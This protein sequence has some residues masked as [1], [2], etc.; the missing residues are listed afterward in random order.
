M[1]VSLWRSAMTS[2]LNALLVESYI[3]WYFESIR[4]LKSKAKMKFIEE[5]NTKK[6]QPNNIKGITKQGTAI[7][8][9]FVAF[10]LLLLTVMVCLVFLELNT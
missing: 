7:W 2:K 8:R 4:Y 10:N 1:T 9:I 3:I 5:L 6:N